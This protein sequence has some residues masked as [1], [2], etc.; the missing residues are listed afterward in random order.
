MAVG[1]A[2]AA[3]APLD[4][5]HRDPQQQE[6]DEVGD[7]EGA[8]AVLG[9]LHREAQEVAEADRVAGHR[10]DQSDARSPALAS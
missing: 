3:D 2:V 10:Q 8:A 1:A 4:P 5:H 9:G 7:H 6:R